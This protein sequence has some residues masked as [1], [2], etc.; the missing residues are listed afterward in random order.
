[1]EYKKKIKVMR[2]NLIFIHMYL[3]PM[4]FPSAIISDY[5]Y[6]EKSYIL[7]PKKTSYV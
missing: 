2:S 1:M 7:T 5:F 6:G 3:T 4:I